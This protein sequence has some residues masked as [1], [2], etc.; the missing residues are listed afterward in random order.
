MSLKP[1][2]NIAPV[3]RTAKDA[4]AIL[5]DAKEAGYDSVIVLGFKDGLLF[6]ERSN[7]H[8]NYELL[9]AIEHA[10]FDIIQAATDQGED[11]GN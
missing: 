5:E 4:L 10:K 11:E 2:E 1:V 3:A 7:I 6:V 9:G 8:N